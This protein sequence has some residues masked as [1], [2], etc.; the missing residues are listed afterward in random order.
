MV[1]I[2]SSTNLVDHPMIMLLLK[3]IAVRGLS[4]VA[5]L[6]QMERNTSNS[7]AGSFWHFEIIL[8]QK[9]LS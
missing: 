4:I 7:H 1:A 2:G 5:T 3:Q 8:D 6:D 9:N